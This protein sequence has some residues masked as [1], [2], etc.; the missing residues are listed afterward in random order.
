MEDTQFNNNEIVLIGA[1]G[2]SREILSWIKQSQALSKVK[3][4]IVGFLDDNF[5]ALDGYEVETPILGKLDLNL[6]GPKQSV[7]MAIMDCR[8]KQNLFEDSL[9]KS[10]RIESYIHATC[11]IG[12]R[13]K[14]G[15]GLVML[16]NSL[17]SSDATIGNLVFVN[18]GSQVGHDVIVGDY[19]SIMANVDIGGGAQIGKNVF[20]GSG[21]IILPGVKIPDHTTIGAGSVVIKSLKKPGSYFGNPARKIF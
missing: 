21:A 11:L 2:L 14:V 19:S 5:N 9:L 3:H 16:P 8:T 18:N 20:I 17:I 10:I 6:V 7:I 4:N 12:S 13:T 1:G 15:E